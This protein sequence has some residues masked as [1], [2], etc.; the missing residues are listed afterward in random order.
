MSPT[1][2]VPPALFQ[3]GD[4]VLLV[5][6]KGRRYMTLLSHG[7][8]FYTHIG[9][10]SHDDI[11]GCQMGS[12]A[13]TNK[14]HLLLL[15][16]PTLA[17]FVLEMPRARQVIY[18]KDI[19]AI[20]LYADIFP[21]AR[22]VE[23]GL[24]SGALTMALLRAVGKDGSVVSYE[25]EEEIAQKALGNIQS[26]IEDA[27]NLEV[28]NSDVYQGIDES[29]VDRIISDIPEPWRVVTSVGNVLV[30]GGIFLSFLPTIIQV[31]ELVNTL[32][33]SH[34]FQLVH[35]MELLLRSWHVSKRSVRPDHRMVAHTGFLV[36]ARKALPRNTQ[37]DNG[38]QDF[39]NEKN[40]VRNEDDPV[41]R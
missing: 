17:D 34:D 40:V 29:N 5:D 20:L 6:F 25:I 11:I 16:R 10:V 36:T 35:T 4:D 26:F 23:L 39:S 7:D 8:T 13:T 1:S 15:F 41:E 24:G 9:H 3:E 14:G 19:G 37:P 27:D 28:K 12:W 30:S 38:E 31:H 18:P 22:V 33:V 21:G 2:S 32:N